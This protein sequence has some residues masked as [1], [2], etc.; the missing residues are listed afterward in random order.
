MYNLAVNLST[1]I[2]AVEVTFLVERPETKIRLT[3][4]VDEGERE[5][6]I[7]KGQTVKWSGTLCVLYVNIPRPQIAYRCSPPVA[8]GLARTSLFIS[9][10]ATALDSGSSLPR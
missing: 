7:N 9:T 3:I 5:V 10:V 2:P 4:K 1:S 6:V 8:A